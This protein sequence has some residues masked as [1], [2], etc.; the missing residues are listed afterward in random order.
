MTVLT[1]EQ[2]QAAQDLPTEKLSIPEWGG[3]VFVRSMNVDELQKYLNILNN[4]RDEDLS[5]IDVSKIDVSTNMIMIV[6]FCVVDEQG[7]RMFAE[8]DA[9]W[10]KTKCV[11]AL[12]K[13]SEVAGRLTGIS[14]E[15]QETISKN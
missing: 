15:A 5:Q 12:R 8:E 7:T 13:I 6:I 10:L 4:G 3:D 1:R 11:G 14:V 9:E 2:I